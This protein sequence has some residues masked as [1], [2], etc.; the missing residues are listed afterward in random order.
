MIDLRKLII[1][2]KIPHKL[3]CALEIMKVSDLST[4]LALPI[5]SIAIFISK[6]FFSYL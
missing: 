1:V 4:M 2:V 3:L 6:V 5:A